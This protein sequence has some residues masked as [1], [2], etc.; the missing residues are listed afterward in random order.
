[1]FLP[2]QIFLH[3]PKPDG[4]APHRGATNQVQAFW[5]TGCDATGHG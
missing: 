4:H 1:M 2:A 5:R 3:H